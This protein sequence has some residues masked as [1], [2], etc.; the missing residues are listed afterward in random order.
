MLN[1]IAGGSDL[2][3]HEIESLVGVA[4]PPASWRGRRCC[5]SA[6]VCGSA[7]IS[8]GLAGAAG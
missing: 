6:A 5:S 1:T 2:L 4:G 8:P 7:A 3:A